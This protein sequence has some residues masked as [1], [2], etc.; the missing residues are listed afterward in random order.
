M[1]QEAGARPRTGGQILID[2]L[3]LHGVRQVFCVPGESYLDALNALHDSP[4]KTVICRQEGGAAM[5]AEAQG[6]LSGLPGICFVTRGPGITNASAAIHIADQD[7]TPLI[8]FA[9]QIQRDHREREAFQEL[10]YRAVFGTMTKWAT[11]IDDTARIPEIISRAFHIATSGRPGPVVIALPEDMLSSRVTVADARPFQPPANGVS[12]ETIGQFTDLLAQATAPLVVLGG[13]GWDEA[14]VASFSAFA[15]RFA[16]PVAVEFRRQTLISADHPCYAGDLSLSADP[17]LKQRLSEADLLILVG[18]QFSDIA[19]QAFTLVGIPTPQMTL[20]HV[21]PDPNE[22]GHLYRAD[23]AVVASP[24]AFA[25]A[26]DGVK[27]AAKP[28]WG[29]AA[30]VAHADALAY[31]DPTK[32]HSPG[33]LQ[34]AYIMQAVGQHLPKDAIICNGA[35]NYAIWVHRYH[36]YRAWGSQLAP[37]SGSM[38]YG[39]PASVG[40]KAA[41]PERTVVAF[42]GD[43]CF[44]MHGQEFATA[45][46]Y[47]LP[48]LSIIIDNAMYGTIRMHQER[49]Y[50]GRVSGTE[51]KNPDFAAYARAFGGHGERVEKNDDFVPAL[52]RAI[53]SGK[54]AILHCLVDP[55]ALTPVSTLSEVRHKAEAQKKGA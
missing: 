6:K 24:K 4:I 44:M 14:A 30:T 35:G 42:S 54:P 5:M 43:G 53:A 33:A 37:T 17:K 8:V 49:E 51:L 28:A 9:G 11:E 31:A 20:V 27:P 22:L 50:P 7:S 52:E 48:I 40:A 38:G 13:S 34:M 19:S 47:D 39:L 45:V 2:Q 46:Q 10:D 12:A 29:D 25:R 16:L 32:T 3:Q 15:E 1:T 18:G 36:R 55:E 23:L 41:H 21:H 26:L